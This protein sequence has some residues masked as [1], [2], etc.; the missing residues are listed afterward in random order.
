MKLGARFVPPPSAVRPLTARLALHRLMPRPVDWFA[1]APAAGLMLGNDTYGD[2]WPVARRWCITL[3]RALVAGDPTP[4][5]QTQCLGDY[6]ALT[7]FD[8]AIGQPDDGTPTDRGM[9]DWCTKGVRIN[10]QYL[11]IPHWLTVDPA[12][13]AHTDIALAVAGPLMATWRVPEA[14][15]DPEA[16]TQAPGS[17][18]DWTTIAGEHETALGATDGAGVVKVRTWGQDIEVH[19]EIRRRFMI[20]VDVP[21]DLQAGGWLDATGMTPL[22]EDR[23]ALLADAAELRAWSVG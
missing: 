10:G 6:A 23:D 12:D 9:A 15:L 16:W 1:A 19:P 4:P 18:A 14:M 5:T 8:P 21:L 17:G 13:T 11:D 7:G 2:C 3:R 22:A 20:A